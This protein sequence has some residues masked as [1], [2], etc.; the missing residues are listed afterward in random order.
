MTRQK[1]FTKPAPTAISSPAIDVHQIMGSLGNHTSVSTGDAIRS[2]SIYQGRNNVT[3]FTHQS[4]DPAYLLLF[5]QSPSELGDLFWDHGEMGG[6]LLNTDFS[7][8]TDFG[9]IHTPC[10]NTDWKSG[11]L[12]AGNIVPGSIFSDGCREFHLFYGGSPGGDG[13]LQEELGLARF[14]IAPNGEFE[15]DDRQTVEIRGWQKYYD[16]STHPEKPGISHRQRRDPFVVFHD[17]LYWMF[18]S[19]AAQTT[20]AVYKGCV[21]LAVAENVAGPYTAVRSPLFPNRFSS[22]GEQG[23]FYDC[24]RPHVFYHDG[25]WHLFFSAREKLTHTHLLQ[26]DGPPLTDSSLHHYQSTQI[27]GPY[28]PVSSR[29]VVEG[30]TETGL[31]G[32][33]FIQPDDGKILAYGFDNEKMMLDVTGSWEVLWPNGRPVIQPNHPSRSSANQIRNLLYKPGYQLWDATMLR[34][35]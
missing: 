34:L 27:Q 21:G 23:L 11:R 7:V 15:W 2:P 29:P 31:Y 32:I 33:N 14:I 16:C 30:S 8:H 26:G 24:E 3:A 6:A 1:L 28:L 5:L 10:P 4:A 19:A 13:L 25:H 9:T 20:S 12:L 35:R 22:E 18:V 17:G